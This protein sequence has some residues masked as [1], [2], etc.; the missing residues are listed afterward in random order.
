MK[1]ENCSIDGRSEVNPEA[2]SQD[3]RRDFLK[4]CGRFAAYTTPA[5]LLLL[6]YQKADANAV[7]GPP[8]H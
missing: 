8:P 5:V 3:D 6:N 1:E 2:E 4:K 7:S